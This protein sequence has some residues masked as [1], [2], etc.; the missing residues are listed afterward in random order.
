MMIERAVKHLDETVAPAEDSRMLAGA[1]L[2]AALP[3]KLL[4]DF[5]Q[6]EDARAHWR[7]LRELDTE[8]E[9]ELDRRRERGCA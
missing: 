5:L 1:V 9:R 2:R 4:E 6:S 3:N 8:F 7:A